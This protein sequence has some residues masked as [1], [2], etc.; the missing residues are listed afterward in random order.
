MVKINRAELM[1]L[2]EWTPQDHNIFLVGQQGI[3]K[4]QMVTQYFDSKGIKTITLFLG[5][6]SDAGDLLGLPRPQTLPDGRQITRFLPPYWWEQSE[7]V[8]LFLDEINRAR[9]E[10]L[11]AVYELVLNKSLGGRSLPKGSRVVAAGNWGEDYQVTDMDPALISRF[12]M[13]ELVPEPEEWLDWAARMR[14]D[15]RVLLF[16]A[17]NEHLLCP[18]LEEGSLAGAKVPDHRAWHRAAAIVE[19]RGT[20][21]EEPD[22][23]MLAGIVGAKA[24]GLFHQWILNPSPLQARQVLLGT[25]PTGLAE[26]LRTMS[27]PQLH[28]FGKLILYLLQSKEEVLREGGALRKKILGN[29][30]GYLQAMLLAQ[31]SEVASAFCHRLLNVA[32]LSYTVLMDAQVKAQIENLISREE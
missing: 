31:K 21:L 25:P 13:Y 22:I 16:L 26:T 4:S 1:H 2:L 14:L 10:I 30:N 28:Q 19:K 29:L 20:V 6:M 32:S 8:V 9:P 24:A 15:E 5:Q 18:R 12:N 11:Q 27:V 23:K 17:E 7:P 3:G